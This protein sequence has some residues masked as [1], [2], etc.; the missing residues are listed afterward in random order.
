MSVARM[1]FSIA[2]RLIKIVFKALGFMGFK[3]FLMPLGLSAFFELVLRDYRLGNPIF[4][5]NPNPTI[6][7]YLYASF[8]CVCGVLAILTFIQNVIRVMR[9]DPVFNIFKAIFKPDRSNKTKYRA[10]LDKKNIIA[11]R[12]I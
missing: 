7:S 6:Y 12:K 10:K 3:W 8:T 9:K 11:T 1:C 2:I 4:W 5:M